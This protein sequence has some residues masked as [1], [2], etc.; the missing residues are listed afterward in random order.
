MEMCGSYLI[1]NVFL[2]FIF[3]YAMIS[4]CKV[5]VGDLINLYSF[6]NWPIFLK[7]FLLFHFNAF[8]HSSHYYKIWQHFDQ[9]IHILPVLTSWV[10]C[11]HQVHRN[12]S[13]WHDRFIRRQS[14]LSS[15]AWKTTDSTPFT[16]PSR[17]DCLMLI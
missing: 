16:W 5:G 4:V 10:L 7:T 11:W 15:V 17:Q 9:R 3:S 8:K 1:Q 2:Q 14:P 12:S 13:L 6:K